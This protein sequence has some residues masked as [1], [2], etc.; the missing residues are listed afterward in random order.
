MAFVFLQGQVL[1][2]F[3]LF[4][5]FLQRQVLNYSFLYFFLD[6][7]VAKTQGFAPFPTKLRS[8]R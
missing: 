3:L 8:L 7:K 6:K 4:V 5:V 2:L 1:I